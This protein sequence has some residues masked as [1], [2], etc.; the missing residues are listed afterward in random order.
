MKNRLRDIENSY[1]VEIIL[2]ADNGSRAWGYSSVNSDY[3]I[4]F[5]YRHKIEEYK[6]LNSPKDFISVKSECGFW[7]FN[8]WDIKKTL[9]L[10]YKGN[11]QPYELVA[12]NFKCGATDTY[13]PLVNFILEETTNS[14]NEILKHYFGLS[15]RTFNERVRNTGEVTLKKYFYIIRPLWTVEYIQREKSLPP[16]D[17]ETLLNYV[18]KKSLT[19][20]VITDTV[21]ELL[22][23]KR[24]GLMNKEVKQR[25]DILDEYLQKRISSLDETIFELSGTKS[26]IEKYDEIY[27]KIAFREN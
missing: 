3:D 27:R 25:V 17:F 9:G 16:L 12:S 18:R 19:D 1:G 14:L 8:G 11:A 20:S 5:V 26:H 15:K 2:A 21:E 6:K 24:D 22:K 7:D 10:L 13:L 23:M 4:K